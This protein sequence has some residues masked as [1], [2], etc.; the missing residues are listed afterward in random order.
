MLTLNIYVISY[1]IR[2]LRATGVMFTCFEQICAQ[3]LGG[4]GTLWAAGGL[5]QLL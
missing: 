5:I 3:E 1:D 2:L 4:G